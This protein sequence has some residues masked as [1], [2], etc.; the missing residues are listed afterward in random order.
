MLNR[1]FRRGRHAARFRWHRPRTWLPVLPVTALLVGLLAAP[2]LAWHPGPLDA[3]GRCVDGKPVLAYT[4][5]IPNEPDQTWDDQA[6]ATV[7]VTTSVGGVH[8]HKLGPGPDAESGQFTLPT[9]TTAA[10]LK[11]V[12]AWD[13]DSPDMVSKP[14]SF[15]DC[16]PP[17]PPPPPPPVAGEGT[18]SSTC[19]SITG[20]VKGAER[21]DHATLTVGG[22]Q[23]PIE[24]KDGAGSGKVSNLKPDSYK[25]TLATSKV[26]F[27]DTITVKGCAVLIPPDTTIRKPTPRQHAK[28][29]PVPSRPKAARLPF[30]G[31]GDAQPVM[32]AAGLAMM[33]AGAAL[34]VVARRSR[35]ATV[36]MVATRAAARAASSDGYHGPRERISP[37]KLAAMLE[38]V[39]GK[40]KR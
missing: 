8:V 10:T 2:A 1:L 18:V 13:G 20:T 15:G 34:V 12:F 9:G 3:S 28:E 25:V 37:A 36:D 32:L 35:P 24:L 23:Y 26:L 4:V 40:P 21:V 33:L 16:T 27:S 38:S 17:P 6:T 14:V 19:D 39:F 5:R 22:K 31:P 30:T 11:A 29:A 7:K